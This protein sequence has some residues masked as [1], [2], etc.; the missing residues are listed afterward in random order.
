M[1]QSKLTIIEQLAQA[2]SVKRR[3]AS[4]VSFHAFVSLYMG[5]HTKQ[6]IPLFH[7]EMMDLLTKIEGGR[8]DPQGGA[9]LNLITPPNFSPQNTNDSDKLDR[10]L[11]QAPRG[12]AKSTVCS[13]FFPLWLALFGKRKDIF[14]VSATISLS[15]ENLRFI[16][17]EI[18]N[19]ELIRRDFG[20][21]KS[22][23]WTEEEIVLRNGTTIRAKGRGFQIRGFRPDIIICDDLEDEEVIY[24][25]EQREKTEHWFFRTL[26]PALKPNQEVVYVGTKLHQY[27]LISKLEQKPEFFARKYVALTDGKSLWE[28]VWS[29]ESLNRIRHEMGEYAFQAEYMNNPI[30]LQDQP[31]KPDYIDN[32]RVQG[33]I[34]AMCLAIDPAIS[35]KESS[36]ERA[37]VL[38]ARTDQNEFKEIYSESGRWNVEEQIRRIIDIYLRYRKHFATVPKD[39]FRVVVESVAFQKVFKDI[40]LKEARKQ[41]IWM[42]VSEAELGVGD[43]KRPKDKFTRLMQVVH[44]FEQKIV[45]I[46]NPYLREELIAFPQGESDNLVDACVFSLYWLMQFR[47]GGYIAKKE[48]QKIID[49]KRGFFVEEIRPGVYVTKTEGEPQMQKRSHFFK[50]Q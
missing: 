44:L 40:L 48:E 42:P 35:E 18:D 17:N 46:S 32:V 47:A 30:S 7:K 23:K 41:N 49:A 34:T 5:G 25:K 50:L 21:V 11:I 28:E 10:L 15:K 8:H 9:E 33:E 31:I 1:L 4:N 6:R 45:E 2:L 39:S 16:R 38:M 27:S 3:T 19:N 36:D 12:F 43:N 14:I 29:T 37:F 13:R 20:E 26:L 24:S 22:E